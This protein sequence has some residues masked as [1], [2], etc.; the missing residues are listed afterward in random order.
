MTTDAVLSSFFAGLLRA[1][2][3]TLLL[4]YDGTLA[5]FQV[6]REQA[7]PYPG[8][9]SLLRAIRNETATRLVIV[10]GRAIDDLLPLL[11][12]DP[13]PEIWGGHGW[14]RLDGVG[15][16]RL[17]PLSAAQ[18]QGLAAAWKIL[19]ERRLVPQ[20]ERKPASVAL[21]WRGL[22]VSAAQELEGAILQAWRPLAGGEDLALHPFDGG[23]ELRA[24]GRHKGTAVEEVLGELDPGEPVAYL[25]DDLTDEDGFGAVRG[26]GLAI[27]VRETWRSTLAEVHLR[28]PRE[29]LGFLHEWRRCAPRSSPS[30]GGVI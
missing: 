24:A 4:D 18:Q 13:P 16:R 6:D 15:E 28:P 1:R 21:H 27:L 25:G 12:L 9:R 3:A 14:E 10:S 17:H 7:V 5:P 2:R 26:R 19:E 20:S 23:M 11:G 8:V 30:P 22:P 29:L